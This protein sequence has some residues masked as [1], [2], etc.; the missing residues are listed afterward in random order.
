MV[1]L[2]VSLVLPVKLRGHL[3]IPSGVWKHSRE[4]SGEQ[5][6]GNPTLHYSLY[7]PRFR[8]LFIYINQSYSYARFP[9]SDK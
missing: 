3:C 5:Q 6:Q 1:V 2:L 7:Y 9:F 8:H 4:N